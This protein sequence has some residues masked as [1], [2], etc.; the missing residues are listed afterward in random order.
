MDSSSKPEVC[1][2]CADQNPQRDR[3]RGITG[4]S[5]GL[6]AHLQQSKQVEL[7]AIVSRSSFAPSGIRCLR[8]PFCSDYLAGRLVA[9]HGHQLFHLRAPDLWHYPKGFLPFILPRKRAPLVGTVADTILQYY[10][11][12]YPQTR[13]RAAFG[14]WLSLLRYS[15]AR[16]DLIIT[17]SEFSKHQIL[18]FCDRHRIKPPPVCVSYEGSQF[19]LQDPVAS[20]KREDYVVHLAS[21]QPHKRTNWL[22][23]HWTLLQSQ[24]ADLPRLWLI[25]SVDAAGSA[26]LAK[27]HA[28]SLTPP[29]SAEKLREIIAQARALLLPSEIEGFGLAAI[30][31]YQLGTPVLY[32]R[33]TAVEEILGGGTAGG[34]VFEQDSFGAA[35]KAVLDCGSEEIAVKGREMAKKYSWAHCVDRTLEAYQHVLRVGRNE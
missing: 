20:S 18:R 26:L 5:R 30:E 35:V 24:R 33:G 23:Q 3:S 13:S 17:V 15:V 8:L 4:Y 25:G 12:H 34:F 21:P 27:T 32:A 10:V 28:V 19:A 11:D 2:Y 1:F 14:Y 9:D 31:A 7:S 16:F 6:L 29:L 22:L